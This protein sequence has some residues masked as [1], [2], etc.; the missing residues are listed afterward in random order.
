MTDQKTDPKS[1]DCPPPPTLSGEPDRSLELKV[2]KHPHDQDAKVDLGSDESMDASDP[3]S[4]A[5]PGRSN[6][7]APSSGFPENQP[8]K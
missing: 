8:K 3:S 5:Q 6:E 2:K 7:P 4:A 1:E